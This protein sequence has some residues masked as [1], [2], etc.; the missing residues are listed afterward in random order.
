VRQRPERKIPSQT[1]AALHAIPRNRVN[2]MQS[3]FAF[4]HASDEVLSVPSGPVPEEA[5]SVPTSQRCFK[6]VEFKGVDAKRPLQCREI[7]QGLRDFGEQSPN[8]GRLS[9]EM[10]PPGRAAGGFH[11][12][13]TPETISEVGFAAPEFG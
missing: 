7:E 12:Q 9:K 5:E 13:A 1:K 11:W 8:I 4:A 3:G 2:D 10:N 6:P